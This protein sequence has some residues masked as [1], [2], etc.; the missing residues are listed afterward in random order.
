M[1][2]LTLTL[3]INQKNSLVSDVLMLGELFPNKYH[4]L[5]NRPNFAAKWYGFDPRFPMVKL[6][7]ASG[8]NRVQ[9]N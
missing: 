9:S 3:M 7:H 5:P 2:T 8:I 4:K 6:L 1:A